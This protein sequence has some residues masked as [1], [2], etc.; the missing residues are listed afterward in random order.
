[1]KGLKLV[2]FLDFPPFSFLFPDF[3]ADDRF[4]DELGLLRPTTFLSVFFFIQTC[5]II[6]FL[7]ADEDL[8][9]LSSNLSRHWSRHSSEAQR[10]L[11]LLSG[12][13]DALDF[14][15]G[16]RIDLFLFVHRRSTF[17]AIWLK[18]CTCPSRPRACSLRRWPRPEAQDLHGWGCSGRWVDL[19][20]GQARAHCTLINL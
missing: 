18:R 10:L 6:G 3:L 20:Q 9:P 12:S 19:A 14:E 2:S 1:M 17:Y 4:F 11:G 8:W 16:A 7:H 15:A 13:W 5:W